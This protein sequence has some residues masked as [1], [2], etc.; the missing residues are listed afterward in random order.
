MNKNINMK[1]KVLL[2]TGGTGSFGKSVV[3]SYLKSDLKEIRIFSRDES[4]QDLMRNTYRDNKLKFYIG[5][6]RDKDSIDQVC[7]GVDFIFHAA[8]LKQVPSCEFFPMEA[9]KTNVIGTENLLNSAISSNVEAVICLSTDKAV[10]PINSM[11]TSKAMM[12]KIAIAKSRNSKNTRIIITR[13]GNVIA[14]R[15]SVVPFFIDQININNPL[16]VTDPKMTRFIM[17]LS[18][19]VQLVNYAFMHGKTGEIYVKKS[20]SVDIL[21]LAH[22]V[23]KL[24]GKPNHEIK[25]IGSRHG[26]KMREALLSREERVRSIE[27]ENYFS[28]KPDVRDLDYGLFTAKGDIQINEGEEYNSENSVRLSLK[29]I[30]ALLEE[31]KEVNYLL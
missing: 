16:T 25:I 22:A 31:N 4:K 23:K 19:A 27:T 20:P 13:Y 9:V 29:E 2:V 21:T 8:A 7:D 24:M 28:V 3:D 12:E 11:G 6:V 30:I 1:D 14:S 26:E 15:G 10:Y 5:D 17:S 18:E